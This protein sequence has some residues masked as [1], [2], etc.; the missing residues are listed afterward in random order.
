MLS[1][2]PTADDPDT[3][4]RKK[5]EKDWEYLESL[6]IEDIEE[7]ILQ[8][9]SLKE[10]G[11]YKAIV[12]AVT[13]MIN[14]DVFEPGVNP[15]KE[16]LLKVPFIKLAA[17]NLRYR[18]IGKPVPDYPAFYQTVD[19]MN[20]FILGL[21]LIKTDHKIGN[22]DVFNILYNGLYERLAFFLDRFD[23]IAEENVPKPEIEFFQSLREVTWQNK[24]TKNFFKKFIKV[25]EHIQDDIFGFGIFNVSSKYIA[26]ENFFI[27]F[28]ISCSAVNYDRLEIE[29]KDVIRADNTFF[30]LI[31]T[32]VTK[33]KAIPEWAQGIAG[34]N[35]NVKYDGYLVCKKCDGYYQLEPGESPENFDK[36]QCGGEL[37]Y[38]KELI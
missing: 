23:E 17:E 7:V 22:E 28:L 19:C 24:E 13:S 34:Y 1:E 21:Y 30:K 3:R 26:T 15:S 16:E 11:Y 4:N 5:L 29:V 20:A 18:S 36:C 37:E 25:M 33:Y 6:N 31:K 32:D 38:K 12:E 9:R 27:E 2:G 14:E 35:G 10:E 8:M